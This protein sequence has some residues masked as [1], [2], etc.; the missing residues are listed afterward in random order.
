MLVSHPSPG[1]EHGG[2]WTR[3]RSAVTDDRRR[4][5]GYV[6]INPAAPSAVAGA[7]PTDSRIA[8]GT[9]PVHHSA[10]EPVDTVATSALATLYLA[11]TGE[12]P[13]ALRAYHEHDTLLML[14]RFDRAKLEATAGGRLEP[15]IDSSL[16]AM[17]ALV[18]EAVHGR[19]GHVLVPGNLSISVE[20]GLAVFAFTI[21]E[22]DRGRGDEL[23]AAAT[24]LRL[25]ADD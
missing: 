24:V 17:P 5:T 19:T 16:M 8:L 9:Q 20:R 13:R 10:E 15:L 23:F 21:G 7:G 2:S 4:S 14:L 3:V 18:A 22:D 12:R 25:S 6:T 11:V 1:P